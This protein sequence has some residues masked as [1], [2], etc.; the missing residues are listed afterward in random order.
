MY[1]IRQFLMGLASALLFTGCA[2]CSTA[3]RQAEPTIFTVPSPEMVDV[4]HGP[5]VPFGGIGTGFSVFGKYGFVD[6]YF[7][8]RHLDAHDWRIDRAP[9]EKPAFA[10]ELTEGNK[11]MVLIRLPLID[12]S[13]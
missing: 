13:F 6:V 2:A 3:G 4:N 10:F 7:D 12:Y 5:G 8:G 1:L 11:K 9:R